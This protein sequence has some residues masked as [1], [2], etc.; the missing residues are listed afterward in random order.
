MTARWWYLRR[1]VAWPAL[2]GCCAAATLVTGLLARWPSAA[3]VLLPA[4]LACCAAGSA[5]VFDEAAGAL[6]AVTPR[7]STWRRTTRLA[8]AGVPL[9]VWTAAVLSRPGDLPL[10]RPG[11][12]LAGAATITLTAGLAA[13]ASRREFDAP[14]SVLVSVVTLAALAPVVVTM[15]LGWGSIYPVEGFADGA[16]AFW[17]AVTAAGALTCLAALRPGIRS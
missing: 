4:L 1:G 12:W 17:L 15:L 7:G 6:L 14:G 5:F 3:L 16:W 9:G 10:H 2:L 11:W 13:L 8:A